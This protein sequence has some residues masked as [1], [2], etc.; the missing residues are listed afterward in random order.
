MIKTVIF[1]CYWFPPAN[2]I[3]AIR[4]YQQVQYLISKGYKVIVICGKFEDKSGQDVIGNEMLEIIRYDNKITT[5]L[6]P[7]M[8][9]QMD[10]LTLRV[11]KFGLRNV[12]YPD[13]FILNRKSV[14]S[15]VDNAIKKYG[16]PDVVISSALP[17][18]MHVIANDVSKRHKI[19]WIA[20]HR[21][22]WANSPYRKRFSYL[23]FL[24]NKYENVVL[25][26]ASYNIV[27]GERMKKDLEHSLGKSNV[28][29]VRNGAD[30]NEVDNKLFLSEGSIVF[31]YTGILYGGF[32]SP[33]ELFT[34]IS[35]D[36]KLKSNSIINFYGSEKY[37][38][39][40]YQKKFKDIKISSYDRKPKSAIQAIQRES[41]F[42]II[43]LGKTEFEK[44][45]LTGKFYEYIETGRA[46]I[47]LCDEDS[48]L[49]LLINTYN[50]G[51]ATRDS[52]S[53]LNYIKLHQKKGFPLLNL[54]YELTRYCQNE[55]L[56]KLLEDL[57][58]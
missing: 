35:L 52:S 41:H 54:P 58:K 28:I 44:S 53:I 42:L 34:A 3:G 16:K 48:D 17:F 33:E 19:K 1:I 14:I 22:L 49:A 24:D 45:V 57:K 4:P 13:P 23:R 18:S 27:V 39:E 47:A 30:T 55:V 10:S 46:I 8:K 43:A 56:L 7:N 11:I 25:R 6:L 38:I 21:D 12:F 15:I 5:A 32:R 20:D 2:I 9:G 31:S 40:T 37:I 36:E 50:L 26:Q 51:I 29:V